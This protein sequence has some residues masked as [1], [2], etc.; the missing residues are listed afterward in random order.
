MRWQIGRNGDGEH[1]ALLAYG[2]TPGRCLLVLENEHDH[3]EASTNLP[4][5]VPGGLVVRHS[6]GVGE[7]PAFKILWNG[8][9]R[10]FVLL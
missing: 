8:T 3:K 4:A 1:F 10:C 6:L 2:S 5:E 7:T 9:N